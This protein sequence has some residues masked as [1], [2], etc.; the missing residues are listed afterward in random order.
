MRP[1]IIT[2]GYSDLKRSRHFYEKGMGFKASSASKDG[3]VFYSTGASVL[4][5]YPRTSLAKDANVDAKGGGFSGVTLAFNV[6]SKEEVA[7]ILGLAA[8]AGGSEVKAA[9]DAFWGGHSG[10][11]A[12]PDGHLWEVAW[13]PFIAFDE[14]GNL[15]LP[16]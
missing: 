14:N 12:D 11:F 4:A 6:E 8:K 15:K 7:K 2:L 5:L 10:Y 9:Q 13:N 16:D 3:I 1:H